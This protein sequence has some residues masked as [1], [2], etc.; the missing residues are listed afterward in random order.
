MQIFF[1]CSS[2]R[3]GLFLVLVAVL[4]PA[5]SLLP[6][7]PKTPLRTY[8]LD[9]EDAALNRS[10]TPVCASSATTLLVNLPRDQAG[11]DTPRIAYLRQPHEV[12]YYADSQWT[13]TPAR[14][15]VPLLV[16]ALE[17]TGCWR[18]VSQMPAAVHGDYRLDT[19]IIHWQQEFFSSPSRA[20]LTVRI[21]LVEQRKQEVIASRQFEV[22][23]PAPSED[24]P[25]GVIATNRAAEQLLQQVAEWASNQMHDATLPQA[26]GGA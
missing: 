16:R 7:T 6:K 15:L 12:S 22:F 8:I 14:L 13:A 25:G 2:R 11:L 20:H 9:F 18:T 24:A 17:Q 4:L 3:R 19:D 26:S 5:C 23:A 10:A 1:T 21:Q